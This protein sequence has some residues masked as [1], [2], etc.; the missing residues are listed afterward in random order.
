MHIFLT[1]HFEVT[2]QNAPLSHGMLD[3]VAAN[4]FSFLKLLQGIQFAV[5]LL[6][7]KGDFTIRALA[8]A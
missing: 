6:L 7:D 5:V 1:R 2:Y 8:D 4:D 3:L